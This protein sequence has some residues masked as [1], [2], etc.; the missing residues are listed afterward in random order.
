M[1]KPESFKYCGVDSDIVAYRCAF[2]T[3]EK[4]EGDCADSINDLMEYIADRTVS[5]P[6][7]DNF[8]GFLTGKDNFRYSVAK[9]YH[10]KGNRKKTEKPKHFEFARDYLVD[11]WNCEIIHGREA[12]DQLAIEATLYGEDYIIASTD[13]D[14]KTVSGWHFNFVKN[15]FT[16]MSE[17]SS[18]K[19]F[20]EQI[21]TGDR[22]DNIIG[23][24]R[25][26]PKTAQKLLEPCSTE[27]NLFDVCLSAYKEKCT[28]G[29]P[30]ERLIENAQLLHMQRYEDDLWQP[31]E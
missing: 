20:Y 21:L 25:V 24:H 8:R 5:F 19:F 22:T 4:S 31:P 27:E 10:Y 6:T 3:Q 9:T 17:W 13:K 29:D 2:A 30:Y 11:E 16:Y 7:E 18:L 14:L 1:N 26:G 12:D 15:E 28:D 23:L